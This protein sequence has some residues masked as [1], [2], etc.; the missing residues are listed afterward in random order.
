M[1]LLDKVKKV[2]VD[3]SPAE[4][5]VPPKAP[6]P[7]LEEIHDR[8]IKAK[9]NFRQTLAEAEA[10]SKKSQAIH[11]RLFDVS[12]TERTKLLKEKGDADATVRR[13]LV[14]AQGFAK[15]QAALQDAE[16]V[17]QIDRAFAECGLIDSGAERSMSLEDVQKAL[18]EAAL[19]VTKTMESVENLGMTIN[20][21]SGQETAMS[22]KE[23]EEM[24]LWK[25]FDNEPDPVK[26]EKL[27]QQL[28]EKTATPQLALA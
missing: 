13:K 12:P 7:S 23:R 25:L 27:R 11:S 22:E 6:L 15:S 1:G 21:P 2:F 19:I 14:Q 20:V 8:I 24:E 18:Q 4:P 28:E 17:M 5:A 16:I 26:K 3:V 10:A 9:L